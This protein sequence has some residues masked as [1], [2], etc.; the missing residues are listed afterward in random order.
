MKV[1]VKLDITDEQRNLLHILITGKKSK[2]MVSRAMV[3]D[4]VKGMIE[5]A[6]SAGID[7][8]IGDTTEV[9]ATKHKLSPQEE[10]MIERLRTQ[11][12]DDSYCR[13]QIQVV[14]RYGLQP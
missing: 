1:H 13:G 11:G 7:G 10:R 3:V 4:F 12:K 6:T 14:R 8:F 9:V 5:R 2:K